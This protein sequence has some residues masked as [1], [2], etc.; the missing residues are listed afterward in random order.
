MAKT[1]DQAF[2]ELSSNLE[3]TD[4]QEQTRLN[5]A[6]EHSGGGRK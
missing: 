4:L 3:I 6:D 2:K 1:I 5:P